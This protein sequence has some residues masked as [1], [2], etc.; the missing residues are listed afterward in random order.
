[1]RVLIV[2]MGIGE[3]YKSIYERKLY[4]ITTVDQNKPADYWDIEEV[5]G[6]F[7]IAHICTPNFT[8]GTIA[9]HIAERCKIVF[10]E[11]PGLKSAESWEALVHT[12]PNTRFAMVKNNQFRHNLPE[13]YIKARQSDFIIL[14]WHNYNRVPSPGS[15]F[16][17]KTKA[18]GG[19]SRDLLPHLLSWIQ[20]FEANFN[21]LKLKQAA[22]H[23]IYNLDTVSTTD[24]GT[25]DPYGVYDVDDTAELHYENSWC[26]YHCTTSWKN[27]IGDKINIEFYKGGEIIHTEP[28]GLCPEDAYEKMVDTAV[29][30]LYNDTYWREQFSRDVWIHSQL[31]LL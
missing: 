2:G 23:Q 29:D 30:N 18:W 1:M 5:Q 8:H 15:W 21:A 12:F 19:V 14:N 26:T 24:Y 31:E 22:T 4:N 3:L 9:R 27:P 28:L 20:V 13:L 6:D 25:I 17:D 10:V 11:K 7:D 16:T